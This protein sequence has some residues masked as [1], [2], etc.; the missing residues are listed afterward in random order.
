MKYFLIFGMLFCICTYT[1]ACK[2]RPTSHS[3]MAS[4]ADESRFIPSDVRYARQIYFHWGT[5][6]SNADLLALGG[7]NFYGKSHFEDFRQGPA[8]TINDRIIAAV[9]K[10][11][12]DGE[13]LDAGGPG[14]YV[15]ASPGDTASYGTDLVIVRF[16]RKIEAWEDENYGAGIGKRSDATSPEKP[17]FDD[18][19]L[20]TR[21]YN[22]CID[23]D[24]NLIGF[25]DGDQYI[26]GRNWFVISRFPIDKDAVRVE[27]GPPSENLV[28]ES[29]E[30]IIDESKQHKQSRTR[31]LNSLAWIAFGI[32]CH[33]NEKYQGMR[34]CNQYQNA[35]KE[36]TPATRMFLHRLFFDF[37]Y[38][39]LEQDIGAKTNL[40]KTELRF[41][42]E[43]LQA[44]Q[45]VIPNDPKT[46][47]VAKMITN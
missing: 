24:L 11:Y 28:K 20:I 26:Y 4:S 9:R 17:D 18:L 38:S 14:V 23:V 31:M 21:Y 10:W 1:Y 42:N 39:Y 29:W 27:L 37:G 34:R 13:R 3:V 36:F 15:S 25:C 6:E 32:N 16:S 2:T 35:G 41:M 44:F 46:E 47:F 43:I 22:N 5:P 7:F 12:A 30:E 45:A 8:A 19:P 33:Q 40:T